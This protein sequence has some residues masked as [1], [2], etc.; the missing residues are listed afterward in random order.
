[1]PGCG[2]VGIVNEVMARRTKQNQVRV[3][4]VAEM[5]I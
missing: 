4:L 2:R 3:V 5:F 1:M